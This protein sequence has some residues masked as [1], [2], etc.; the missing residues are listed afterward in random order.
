M[1]W[2]GQPRLKGLVRKGTIKALRMYYYSNY[3]LLS[4]TSP[5]PFL[6]SPPLLVPLE[7]V[8]AGQRLQIIHQPYVRARASTSPLPRIP[9]CLILE[10]WTSARR[11]FYSSNLLLR[12]T[13]KPKLRHSATMS[14]TQTTSGPK[15]LSKSF[16]LLSRIS[17]LRYM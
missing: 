14:P 13:L 1:S 2:I 12:H 9:R 8:D 4:L 5:H 15:T 16:P 11:D 6:P 3:P 7:A 17:L 10:T